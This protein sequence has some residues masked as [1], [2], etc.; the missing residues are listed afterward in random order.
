MNDNF[1]YRLHY[2]KDLPLLQELI[3]HKKGGNFDRISAMRI[4][5]FQRALFRTKTKVQKVET[6]DNKDFFDVINLYGSSNK[7]W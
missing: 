4:A 7:K 1:K 5:M 2:I 3:K 6:R